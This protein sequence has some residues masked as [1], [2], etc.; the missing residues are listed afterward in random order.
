MSV[1]A[2]LNAHITETATVIQV[3]IINLPPIICN[4]VRENAAFGQSKFASFSNF[5]YS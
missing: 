3:F 2:T 5:S 1:W 4:Q